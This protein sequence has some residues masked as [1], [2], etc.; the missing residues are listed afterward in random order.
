MLVVLICL[1]RSIPSES[2]EP[3][4]EA[5]AKVE[6]CNGAVGGGGIFEEEFCKGLPPSG[7]AAGAGLPRPQNGAGGGQRLAVPRGG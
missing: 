3:A 2:R 6:V 4:S 5:V 1:P 7:P